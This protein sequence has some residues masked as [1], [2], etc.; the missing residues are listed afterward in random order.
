MISMAMFASFQALEVSTGA[1]IAGL[2][3]VTPLGALLSSHTSAF[4]P[5]ELLVKR[6]PVRLARRVGNVVSHTSS[7]HK[8]VSFPLLF[9]FFG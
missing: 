8:S 7:S 6:C 4:G 9:F 1:R 2:V 3:N 5:V